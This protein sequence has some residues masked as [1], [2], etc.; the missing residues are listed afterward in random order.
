MA[1][2]VQ[3]TDNV[4][5]GDVIGR[6]KHVT[7]H[8]SA[9]TTAYLEGLYK[10]FLEEVKTAEERLFIDD[11]QH[12]TSQASGDV[13]G[14]EEKLK[15]GNRG[16]ILWYAKDL[17]ERYHKKLIRTSQFSMVAQKINLHLLTL[18]RTN[19]LTE[20]YPMIVERKE[21]AIIDNLINEK[22]VKPLLTELG[23]NCLEFNAD[24]ILGMVYY[25]TGNC[26][27]KWTE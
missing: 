15:A 18:I 1:N 20:I 10:K 7:I 13:L 3:I 27:I 12:Y 16:E 21:K 23:E 26:H 2:E 17:K 11:L 24:H 6:D 22:I 14:L 19:Y 4:V 9:K 8:P 25:L 5:T